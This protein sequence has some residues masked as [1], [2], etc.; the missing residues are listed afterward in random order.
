MNAI[1]IMELISE[2]APLVEDVLN[3]EEGQALSAAVI[4]YFNQH[5]VSAKASPANT[6]TE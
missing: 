3:S 2:I 4:N 1:A 5:P 6:S